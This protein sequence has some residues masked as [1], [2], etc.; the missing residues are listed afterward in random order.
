VLYPTPAQLK[1]PNVVLYLLLLGHIDQETF[2][3]HS[4]RN[5][6]V[7]GSCVPSLVFPFGVNPFYSSLLVGSV[8]V[9][10]QKETQLS[11]DLCIVC[12]YKKEKLYS[13]NNVYRS[14]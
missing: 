14:S 3:C 2:Q 10:Q 1:S 11:L 4:G 6:Q 9:K 8:S 5:K 7:M 12:I 13:N